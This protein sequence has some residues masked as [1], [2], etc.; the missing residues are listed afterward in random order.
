MYDIELDLAAIPTYLDCVGVGFS[1]LSLRRWIELQLSNNL[2]VRAK[3]FQPSDV[4]CWDGMPAAKI[5][6]SDLSLRP[7]FSGETTVHTQ[8]HA[9]QRV[10]R[11]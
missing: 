1:T 9:D 7:A 11:Y 4:K 3:K 5:C 2:T 6:G 10:S 8:H